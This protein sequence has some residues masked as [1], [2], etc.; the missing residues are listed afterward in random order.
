MLAECKTTKPQSPY[1]YQTNKLKIE[2]ENYNFSLK[3][4]QGADL[5]LLLRSNSFLAS[6]AAG[7]FQPLETQSPKVVEKKLIFHILNDTKVLTTLFCQN[8][9]VQEGLIYLFFDSKALR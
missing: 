6:G 5:L 8:N 4:T 2:P 9:I 3:T 7:N 1:P